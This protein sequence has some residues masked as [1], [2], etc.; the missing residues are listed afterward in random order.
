VTAH[1]IGDQKETVLH[2]DIEA[3]LVVSACPPHI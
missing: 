3:I 1:A 2:V